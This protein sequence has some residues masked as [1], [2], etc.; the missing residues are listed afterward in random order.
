MILT[1]LGP[2]PISNVIKTVL[3]KLLSFP[4]LLPTVQ[5][6]KPPPG[7]L[8]AANIRHVPVKASSNMTAPTVPGN[9]P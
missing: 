5:V 7:L 4:I 8:A 6:Q 3:A 2:S 1:I 9:I